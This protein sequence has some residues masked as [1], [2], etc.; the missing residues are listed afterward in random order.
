VK[1]L[2][3]AKIHEIKDDL[4]VAICDEELLGKKIKIKEN[5]E[6]EISEEFYGGKLIDEKNA[7][8]LIK[9]ATIANL[10]GN[11]IVE[12]AIR[13]NLIEK[14]NVIEFKGIKHAQIIEL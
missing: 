1:F 6:I 7:I 2:F 3:W 11:K 8:E 13:E 4:V 9:K 14:E 10:F 12:I 5:F